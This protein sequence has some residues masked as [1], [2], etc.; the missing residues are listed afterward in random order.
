MVRQLNE[1]HKKHS[2]GPYSPDLKLIQ[3]VRYQKD[4]VCEAT[5][6]CLNLRP[7]SYLKL[8]GWGL[9]FV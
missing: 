5:E 2:N 7:S 1:F 6:V 9:V 4:T 3:Q 8:V